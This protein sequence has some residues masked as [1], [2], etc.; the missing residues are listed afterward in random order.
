MWPSF[1][2]WEESHVVFCGSSPTSMS[3]TYLRPAFASPSVYSP[4]VFTNKYPFSLCI[5]ACSS[6]FFI[7]SSENW[8][9]KPLA[10]EMI[11]IHKPQFWHSFQSRELE[12]L[13][14]SN[15]NVTGV[16]KSISWQ[17]QV[18]L[19]QIRFFLFF[20]LSSAFSLVKQE[21]YHSFIHM[22]GSIQYQDVFERRFIFIW[23]QCSAM[24]FLKNHEHEQILKNILKRQ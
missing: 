22:Y 3:H 4:Y 5:T 13:D 6:F 14:R 15:T 20:V 19:L 12:S 17:V 11:Y 2:F 10:W 23:K 7:P 21:I 1:F 18:F 8:K 24:G 16:A 9:G